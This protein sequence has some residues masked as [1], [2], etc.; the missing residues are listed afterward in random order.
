MYKRYLKR[1]L[2]FILSLTAIII[3]SPFI[4]LVALMVRVKLGN[5]IIF[6]QERPGLNERVFTLYKFR[7]MTDKRDEKGEL[8][9]DSYRLTKF[10]KFL[11]STSLDELPELFNILKGDMSIVGPRPLLVEYLPYYT[12]EEKL[13]H[14]VR[15]GLTGFAQ[16][17]G[18]NNLEWDI[19]LGFDVEYVKNVTFH[20]D[21][22]IIAK[23]IIK[24][25][26]REGIDVVVEALHVERSNKNNNKNL[27][28]R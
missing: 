6:K 4:L 26:K 9:P 13:R 3:L 25:F 15:P 12:E 8:L 5:P 28:M 27:T 7:T 17:N 14:T 2:D 24:V 20:L 23:T 18:R 16:V 21:A 11:R 19:R 1:A 10:G 22:L